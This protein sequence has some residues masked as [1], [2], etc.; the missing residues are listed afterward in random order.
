MATVLLNASDIDY[1]FELVF[2]SDEFAF[3]CV[4]L[5]LVSDVFVFVFDYVVLPLVSDVF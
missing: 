5:P 1:E 4:V 2:D 3:D